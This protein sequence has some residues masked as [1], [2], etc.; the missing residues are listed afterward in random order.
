M[1]LREVT[2]EYVE[3]L[4][5]VTEIK[6]DIVLPEIQDIL[7]IIGPRR[8]GKTFLMLK[9]AKKLIDEGKQAIYVSFDDPAF[10]NINVRKFGE[11]VRKEYPD[12]KVYL[13]LDEVQ[14][15][16]NW[17]FNIRWLHDVKDFV[18]FVSGSSS[19]LQ[20]SEI[21]SRLRGRYI[22]KL[23]LP[24]SFKEIVNFE[25]KTFR[26]RG[27]AFRVLEDYLKWGGFPEVWLYKSRE[28]VLSI[29]ETAFYRDIV[30]RQR[31]KNLEEFKEFFY[32]VISNYSNRFTYNSLKKV[33][34]SYGIKIDTKTVIKY[35]NSMKNAF[36]IFPIARFSYSE[37]EKIISPK[38]IYVVDLSFSLFFEEK[39]TLGRKMENLVFLELFRRYG[40]VFYYLTKSNKEIDFYIP[41][42]KMLIEVTYEPE[43]GE[44]KK[45]LEAMKEL[46][47]EESIVITWDYEDEKEVSWFGKTGKVKFMPL[48]KWLLNKNI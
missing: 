36:L 27:R 40:D 3:S 4:K 35:I 19:T 1:D 17:D 25:I 42:K 23:I 28:K 47:I 31:I 15:W 18:I 41:K 10:M 8:V 29:L 16:K 44:E 43:I 45:I 34:E 9:K 39:L 30:E 24:L 32:F 14:E 5:Y 11:L 20:S 33:L 12:G 37:R 6:R 26:E 48:W 13:F 7:A 2:F 46:K 21:P 22:S 38:K